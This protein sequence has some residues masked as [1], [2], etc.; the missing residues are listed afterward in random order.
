MSGPNV[1]VWLARFWQKMT[2][3]TLPV[4]CNRIYNVE[5]TLKSDS[6]NSD[7]GL[8]QDLANK[9]SKVVMNGFESRY[10]LYEM[11]LSPF[12]VSITAGKW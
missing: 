1:L 11:I 9:F 7:I 8:V 4:S 3:N 5:V 2:K 12:A 6:Y 10:G